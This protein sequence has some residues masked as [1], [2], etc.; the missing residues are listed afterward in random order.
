M[1]QWYYADRNRQ[2]QG[3]V[4]AAELVAL[5]HRNEVGSDTLVWRPGL[6][7][8][9]ALGGFA[10][11]LGLR[12]PAATQAAEVPLA[13]TTAPEAE[14]EAPRPAEDQPEAAVTT[15]RAVFTAREP[16]YALPERTPADPDS[17]YAPPRATISAGPAVVHGGEVV[18]AGFWKRVAAYFVDSFI[19]AI[20]GGVIG[21]VLGA[22]LGGSFDIGNSLAFQGMFNV[23]G[24]VLGVCYY[25]WFHAS[26]NQ[27]TPG[28]MAVGIKV[29][30]SDGEPISFMRGVGR[31]FALIPSG[32]ILGIGFLMAAFT[33]RKRS[34]HDMIC[35][36]VVV[37]KWAF[38]DEPHRQRQELGAVTWLILIL[39]G[40]LM[41]AVFAGA[42]A[43]G[44]MFAAAN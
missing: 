41:L 17:P 29:A 24:I 43:L 20:A 34:L 3:P 19:V 28:K 33:D 12:E 2:R 15:S 37:D 35:D 8:W 11:E 36:T 13:A 18:Y 9:Q 23:I 39:G 1:S 44:A 14:P 42:M 5:F 26:G 40:L 10:G 16:E 21:G 32:L 22:I 7:Q 6:E 25:A 30:R 31:Y 38:T 27:A 4:E